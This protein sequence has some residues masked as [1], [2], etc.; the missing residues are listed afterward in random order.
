MLKPIRDYR[1]DLIKSRDSEDRNAHLHV[2]DLFACPVGVWQQKTGRA[3]AEHSD[4]ILR[5][6][7]AGHNIEERLVEAMQHAGILH[8]TQSR[9]S[10]PEYNMVGSSDIIVNDGG[11]FTLIEVKSIHVFGMKHLY[12]NKK[13]HEHY[14]DQVLLYMNQLQDR[15]PGLKAKIYYEALDGRTAEFDV[16]YDA[17]RVAVLL[18]RAAVLARCIEFDTK[19]ELLPDFIQEDG[20]W[21]VNWKNSYC[22]RNGIHKTCVDVPLATDPDKWNNKLNYACKKKNIACE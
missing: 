3:K 6:F 16:E 11:E 4:S 21:K 8:E 10:W 15:F 2:T 19:P 14:R 7:D 13:P 1:T 9:V 12:A 17:K 18:D 20:K 5:R 22:I